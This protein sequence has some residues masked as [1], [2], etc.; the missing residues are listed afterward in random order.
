MIR[1]QCLFCGQALESADINA[2]SI[3]KCPKCNMQVAIPLV[4]TDGSAMQRPVENPSTAPVAATAPASSLTPAAGQQPQILRPA[5]VASG[6]PT[7][8]PP[9]APSALDEL[10]AVMTTPA[11]PSYP[12]YT[13]P[14]DSAAASALAQMASSAG[15]PPLVS[16]YANVSNI[17]YSR[18]H[19][20]TNAP[21]A[22]AALVVGLIGL[23]CFGVIMGII[24]IC[25]GVSASGHIRR[26]PRAYTGGGMAT[27][28]IVLGIIDIIGGFIWVMMILR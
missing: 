25:L 28:G 23:V 17:G 26:N 8:Q 9:T 19:T 24:A 21:N 4:S 7:S 13:S 20:P 11:N 3:R 12:R 14:Q 15:P 22:V 27:A 5:A 2:G 16:P 10:N 1:H 18:Y 6:S